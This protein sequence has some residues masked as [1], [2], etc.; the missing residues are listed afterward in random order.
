MI[1]MGFQIILFCNKCGYKLPYYD[2]NEVVNHLI[3]Q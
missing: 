2:K 1:K 3:L